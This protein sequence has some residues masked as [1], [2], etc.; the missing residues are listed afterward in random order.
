MSHPRSSGQH[1]DR[2]AR[3]AA[4]LE[5]ALRRPGVREMMQV[6]RNWQRA[7]QGLDA[8]RTVTTGTPDTTTSDRVG[9][10]K[11]GGRA[12]PTGAPASSNCNRLRPLQT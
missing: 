12:C 2:A 9:S 11:R 5:E 4:M 7:D 3:C 1:L 6:Y 10:G 8:Y